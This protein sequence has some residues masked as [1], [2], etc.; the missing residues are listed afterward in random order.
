MG[1][2]FEGKSFDGKGDFSK[3][4]FNNFSRDGFSSK[5]NFV[6]KKGFGFVSKDPS[7]GTK[8]NFGYNPNPYNVQASSKDQ[9]GAM[10]GGKDLGMKS[11]GFSGGKDG[12]G[13]TSS[14]NYGVR[15]GGCR[16][17]TLD[18]QASVLKYMENWSLGVE[19]RENGYLNRMSAHSSFGRDHLPSHLLDRDEKYAPGAG[20]CS[21]Y[22]FFVTLTV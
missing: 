13:P 1:G 9:S 2:G 22:N 6:G 15:G 12:K 14:S 5:S 11:G 16:R 8:G 19:T 21:R 7:G 3:D 17:R 4:G 20:I 18:F 10:I